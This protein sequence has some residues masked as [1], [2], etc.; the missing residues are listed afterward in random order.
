[1]LAQGAFA[2]R[3]DREDGGGERRLRP[4]LLREIDYAQGL[5]GGSAAE[6][7][8]LP[9]SEPA[10]PPDAF[11]RRGSRPA[12][13]R[14]ADLYAGDPDQDVPALSQGRSDGEGARLG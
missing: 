14:P 3:S 11:D 5:A 2:A 1:E 12:E 6:G 10:Q 7:H 9:L 8:A 4:A 13:D